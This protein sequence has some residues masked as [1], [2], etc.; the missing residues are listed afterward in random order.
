MKLLRLGCIR[1]CFFAFGD[2][3]PFF[4]PN[5]KCIRNRLIVSIIFSFDFAFPPEVIVRSRVIGACPVTMDCIV[6]MR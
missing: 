2:E 5:E 3:G 1:F 6:A 4:N